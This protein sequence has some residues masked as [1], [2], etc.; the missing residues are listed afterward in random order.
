MS[1]ISSYNFV[2]TSYCMPFLVTSILMVKWYLTVVF[3]S[4][5]LITNNVEYTF[6]CLLA[7]WMSSL[8]NHLPKSLAQLL[9]GLFVFSLLSYKSTLHI[10][11][12]SALSVTWIVSISPPVDYLFTFLVVSFEAQNFLI[13]RKSNLPTFVSLFVLLVI[14]VRNHCPTQCHEDLHYVFF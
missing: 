13:L 10:L 1:V 2:N 8:E 14:Y 11:D 5:S 3:I 6:M 9:I 4:I 7:I 12:T